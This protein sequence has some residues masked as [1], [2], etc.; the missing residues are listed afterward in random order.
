MNKNIHVQPRINIVAS[1]WEGDME[2][3]WCNVKKMD[4]KLNSETPYDLSYVYIIITYW[5]AFW[6]KIWFYVVKQMDS[7]V[8]YSY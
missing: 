8:D 4:N 2:N 5:G 6:K 7:F 1:K 3:I